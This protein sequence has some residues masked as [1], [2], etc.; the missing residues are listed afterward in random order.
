[1]SY[2]RINLFLRIDFF[3]IDIENIYAILVYKK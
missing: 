3:S 2:N 1:M